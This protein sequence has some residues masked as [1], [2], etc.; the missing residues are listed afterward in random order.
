MGGPRLKPDCNYISSMIGGIYIYGPKCMYNRLLLVI[1]R[2]EYMRAKV[3]IV[4]FCR[5]VL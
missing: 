2:N 5:L 4:G 3:S 1:C